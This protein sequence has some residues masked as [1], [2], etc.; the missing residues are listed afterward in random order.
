MDNT[1]WVDLVE[2]GIPARN[3]VWFWKLDLDPGVSSL[4]PGGYR[5]F[6][7]VLSSDIM[8][9]S[10]QAPVTR[11]AIEHSCVVATFGRGENRVEVRRIGDA[12]KPRCSELE[13]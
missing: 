10:K 3:V 4:Y 13:P 9:A 11:A 2:R 6:D 8:R 1:T 7:Y 12:E 5:G